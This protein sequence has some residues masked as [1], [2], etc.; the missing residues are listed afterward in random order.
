MRLLSLCAYYLIVRHL[1]TTETPVIGLGIRRVRR[2]L[3]GRIFKHS[4]QNVNINK[5]VYFGT[6]A[7]ISIGNNS[8]IEPD[9][10]I[11]NDTIIGDDVMIAPEVI[12]FS[13]GHNT[14][15]TDIA[16]RLQGDTAQRPVTIGND[17]WIGQRSIILPGV[18]IADGAIVGAGSVVTK[19]VAEKTVVA[20][21]PA[22]F[23][24]TR[25]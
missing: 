19:N 6:G 10:Q 22:K 2:L 24:K 25:Q 23:I 21:N 16:M 18:F 5:N 14:K 13:K 8:S 20:G 12:I 11:A 4:G 1:P 3:V 17:V 7:D 9:C 15:Q